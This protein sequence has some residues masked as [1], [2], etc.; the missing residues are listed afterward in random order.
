MSK[1][2]EKNRKMNFIYFISFLYIIVSIPG[3]EIL[4]HINIRQ[5]KKSQEVILI[6]NLISIMQKYTG[7]VFALIEPYES[8]Q[9]QHFKLKNIKQSLLLEL[10]GNQ[11]LLNRTVNSPSF[12]VIF[13]NEWESVR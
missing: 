6:Q 5:N 10:K 8:Q 9:N 11:I 12:Y 4:C 1:N 2:N 13:I 3:F 7:S